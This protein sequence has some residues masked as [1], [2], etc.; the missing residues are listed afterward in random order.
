MTLIDIKTSDI[1][2]ITISKCRGT[3]MSDKTRGM[4]YKPF[5]LLDFQPR[6]Y[7]YLPLAEYLTFVG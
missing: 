5:F 2:Y 7:P 4:F 3:A 1:V 6:H